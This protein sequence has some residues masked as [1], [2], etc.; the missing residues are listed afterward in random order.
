MQ[1]DLYS[2]IRPYNDDEIPAA[3]ERIVNDPFFVPAV[4]F[5][6]PE[7]DMERIAEVVRTCKTVDQM[8]ERVML[9]IIKRIIDATI[10]NFTAA[11]ID[12]IEKNK[13]YCLLYYKYDSFY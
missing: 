8:Q 9:S 3:L 12:G 5:A 4:N 1:E 6:F 2:D 7:A 13:G 10:D 11:G